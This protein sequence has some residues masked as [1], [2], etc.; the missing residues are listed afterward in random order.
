MSEAKFTPER[1]WRA[2]KGDVLNPARPWGIVQDLTP[3]ECAEAGIDAGTVVVAEVTIASGGEEADAHLLAAAPDLYAAC[4]ALAEVSAA[5]QSG[6]RDGA[7]MGM[8]S[9]AMDSARAAL[10]K[11]EGGAK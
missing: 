7:T 5:F 3:E 1:K 2:A 11:A 9:L 10:S 8:V 6:K 4:K